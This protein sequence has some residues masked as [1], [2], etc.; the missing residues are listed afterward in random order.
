MVKSR[1]GWSKQ[2]ERP[3][4][5]GLILAH[6]ELTQ[7]L[8]FTHTVNFKVIIVLHRKRHIKLRLGSA[9]V[10]SSLP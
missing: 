5:A 8:T 9:L 7:N 6:L 2:S 1:Q 3:G 10:F 4:E